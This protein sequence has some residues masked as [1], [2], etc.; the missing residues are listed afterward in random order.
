MLPLRTSSDPL[1]LFFC[2]YKEA[3]T[4]GITYLD[5]NKVLDI[6]N[7]IASLLG[8][9]IVGLHACSRSLPAGHLVVNGLGAIEDGVVC[10]VTVDFLR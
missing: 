1:D 2:Q 7:V 4:P 10:W 9:V 3:Y 8:E 6:F 5:S